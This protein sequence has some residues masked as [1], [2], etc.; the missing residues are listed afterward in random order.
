MDELCARRDD[1][2][3]VKLDFV[4]ND[5]FIFGAGVLQESDHHAKDMAEF[6]LALTAKLKDFQAT[7]VQL[8]TGIHT[9]WL[10]ASLHVPPKSF[11]STCRRVDL[12]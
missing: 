2:S 7:G 4:S 3:V 10:A 5:T 9:G 8:K 12:W 1:Y 6:A 11:D